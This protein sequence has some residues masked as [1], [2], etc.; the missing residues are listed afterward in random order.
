ML[1]IAVYFSYVLATC[2]N[3]VISLIPVPHKLAKVYVGD[4]ICFGNIS[5]GIFDFF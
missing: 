2:G 5:M 3:D 1:V 4:S